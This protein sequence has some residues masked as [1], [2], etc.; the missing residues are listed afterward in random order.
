MWD[1]GVQWTDVDGAGPLQSVCGSSIP[2]NDLGI[3]ILGQS[4]AFKREG[5][6]GLVVGCLVTFKKALSIVAG[7]PQRGKSQGLGRCDSG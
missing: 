3:G 4:S 6:V 5:H 7:S 2:V 1:S